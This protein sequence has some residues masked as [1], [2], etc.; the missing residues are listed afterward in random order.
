MAY[1]GSRLLLFC[2]LAFTTFSVFSQAI[3]CPTYN[4][5]NNG[6]NTANCGTYVGLLPSN[7]EKTGEFNFSSGN[8]NL[9]RNRVW[10]NGTLYQDGNILVTNGTV[11]F[12]DFIGVASQ[13]CFFAPN[14]SAGVPP[15]ANWSFEFSNG[16]S[17]TTC[18][19]NI[20]SNGTI[21]T[22]TPGSIGS[23][24]TI[25][26]GST[27]AGLTNTAPASSCSSGSISYQWQQSTSSSSNGFS[28]IPSANSLTFNPGSLTQT[29]Y[30]QR[31]AS[32][33]GDGSNINSNVVTITVVSAGTISPSDGFTWDA[34]TTSPTFTV[35]G[36]TAGGTG[37]WS[38]SQPGVASI[39]AVSG[40]LTAVSA[41]STIITYS[42]SAGGITCT[43]TRSVTIN[44]NNG[45]LP[46]VWKSVTAEKISDRIL[47]RWVTASEQNTRDFEVQHSVNAVDWQSIGTVQAQGR[48]ESPREYSML[49]ASAQKGGVNNFYRILQTDI[50]GKASYSKI[51]SI[52]LDSPGPD[53]M[54]FPNPAKEV[55]SIFIA[56][57]Q[58]LRL[59][60]ASG[61]TVWQGSLPGGRHQL[62]VGQFPK[63]VYFLITGK[64]S[65]R[66]IFQ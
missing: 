27:A 50:D 5:R 38:S 22:F 19:Y 13:I 42:L 29:T 23:N 40:V 65:Q 4:R 32:C 56:E 41:G 25:C 26:A 7:Y 52:L 1:H 28:D 66:L 47:V 14:G 21:S 9:T 24:Q 2:L 48:S 33:S 53:I 18:S 46:L 61:T 64:S 37:T 43:T 59:V 11:W 63:G 60:N 34:S 45:V 36:A 39:D 49:H 30:Y 54:V 15:A 58:L 55:I 10:K 12:G 51:V 8:S 35:S 44:N 20:N 6:N 16:T 17:T 57:P 31:V 3:T 62:S